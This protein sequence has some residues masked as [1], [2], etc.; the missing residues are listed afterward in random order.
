[1]WKANKQTTT[2]MILIIIKKQKNFETNIASSIYF[3]GSRILSMCTVGS[4][5]RTGSLLYIKNR[6]YPSVIR[7]TDTGCSCSIEA[8]SCSSQIKVYLVHFQLR[9]GG[10]SCTGTQQVEIDDN[11]NIQRLT[12]SNNTDYEITM[13]MTSTS[14]YMNATLMNSGGTADGYFWIG[15]EGVKI[16]IINYIFFMQVRFVFQQRYYYTAVSLKLILLKSC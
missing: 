8:A 14:N 10:Q 15:F 1:M 12:C 7:S 2:T 11:G 3:S 5:T 9:D 4:N 16:Y 6:D 13:K